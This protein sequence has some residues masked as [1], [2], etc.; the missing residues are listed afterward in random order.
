MAEESVTVRGA[1]EV[2]GD[3]SIWSI[4]EAIVRRYVPPEDVQ[5]RMEQLHREDRI[6][7]S[8]TPERAL[9]H[10]SAPFVSR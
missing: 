10:Q 8:M 6:I 3:E 2:I 1:S 5:P 7:I 4:T 9:F